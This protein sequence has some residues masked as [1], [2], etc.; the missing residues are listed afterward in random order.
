MLCCK[1]SWKSFFTFVLCGALLIGGTRAIKFG[2]MSPWPAE[3]RKTC[4]QIEGEGG[5][6][7][8]LACWV[9]EIMCHQ[10]GGYK[11]LACRVEEIMCHQIGGYEPLAC[12]VEEITC[13]QTGRYEPLAC[14]VEEI[15]CH[16]IGGYEALA[17]WVG[18]ITCHQVGAMSPW[19]AD[20]RKACSI[21]Y[22]Q[23]LQVGNKQVF[24]LCAYLCWFVAICVYERS[25]FCA[26]VYLSLYVYTVLWWC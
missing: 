25:T 16:Q 18:E 8:P 4:H 3:W 23:A 1:C 11:P 24:V 10:I 26:C 21:K 7:E 14:R 22:E 13:H 12:R 9:E 15:T 6:Y 17:C 20:W 2:D 19:P 5:G